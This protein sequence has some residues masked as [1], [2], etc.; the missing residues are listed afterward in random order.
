[1]IK[2]SWLEKLIQSINFDDYDSLQYFQKILS[3]SGIND[4]L[5]EKGVKD[6]DTVKIDDFEFDFVE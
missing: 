3:S 4:A 2:S 1:M 6:G 5:I